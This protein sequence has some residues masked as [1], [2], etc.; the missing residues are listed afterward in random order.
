MTRRLTQEIRCKIAIW[1][2]SNKS[3]RQTQRHYMEFGINLAPTRRTI[4]VIHPK[5]MKTGSV[6]DAQSRGVR[7]LVFSTLTPLL[8]F[9]N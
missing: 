4:Y 1:Q 9:R 7:S 2:E 6:V 3:V 8:C 5:F